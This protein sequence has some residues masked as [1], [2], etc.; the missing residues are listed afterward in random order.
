M[1]AGIYKTLPF[2]LTSHMDL[3][4]EDGATIK[5]SETFA[6]YGIPDPNLPDANP[7]VAGGRQPVAPLN[8]CRES[9]IVVPSP[10]A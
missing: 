1:R 3:H 2:M 9:K 10:G 6:D 4:L 7:S 5:A 8:S